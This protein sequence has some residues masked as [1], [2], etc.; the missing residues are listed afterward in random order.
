M[1]LAIACWNIWLVQAGVLLVVFLAGLYC[2]ANVV[3]PTAARKFGE[4]WEK[5][6]KRKPRKRSGKGGE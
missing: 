2:C 3:S 4:W 5:L 6:P 1:V